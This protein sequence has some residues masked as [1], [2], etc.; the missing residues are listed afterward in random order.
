[1]TFAKKF[2]IAA[3]AALPQALPAFALIAL[4]Q[5]APCLRRTFPL[6]DFAGRSTPFFRA[7]M[8]PPAI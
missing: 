6:I 5:N 8:R 2:G 3:L 4:G 7:L 1:M